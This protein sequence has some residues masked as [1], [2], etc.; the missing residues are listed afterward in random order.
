MVLDLIFLDFDG[1]IVESNLI[2]D[3]GFEIIFSRFPEHYQKMLSYH[4]SSDTIDRYEKFNYI[5]R[6]ILCE[7]DWKKLGSQLAKDYSDFTTQRVVEC[8]EVPGAIEFL[9]NMYGQVPMILLSATPQEYLDEILEARKLRAYFELAFG[10]PLDKGKKMINILEDRMI[11]PSSCVFIGDS[12]DDYLASIVAGVPF[13][14]RHS[15]KDFP[16]T[17]SH[18]FSNLFQIYE[19]ISTTK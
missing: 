16:P 18:V 8:D 2:K 7:T 19:Y 10:K 13:I 4:Q 15:T 17:V 5:A 3:E 1:V 12:P 14:G 11:L 9:N 6:D